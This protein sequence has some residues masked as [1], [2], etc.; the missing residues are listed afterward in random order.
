MIKE[1]ILI[2]TAAAATFAAAQKIPAT[3]KIKK[4]T[5]TAFETEMVIKD[6]LTTSI[7]FSVK[8]NVISF[9]GVD[10]FDKK[11]PQSEVDKD[12]AD[13]KKD[14]AFKVTCKGR[15]VTVE[16]SFESENVAADFPQATADTRNE[17]QKIM[18]TGFMTEDPSCVVDMNADEWILPKEKGIISY[19]FIGNGVL[20]STEEFTT[21]ESPEQCQQVAAEQNKEQNTTAIC[22]GA[23]IYVFYQ[24]ATDGVSKAAMFEK[25]KP[26][27][28]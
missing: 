13:N 26:E 6:S 7:V 11:V 23:T 21:L 19:R 28:P 25:V 20:T 15:K 14:G 8:K 22:D 4:D 24:G 16:A 12:C 18:E 10:T 3:C 1:S 5:P 9:V 17:C 27:C 2:L